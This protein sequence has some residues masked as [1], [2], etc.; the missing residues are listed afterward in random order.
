MIFTVSFSENSYTSTWSLG[1]THET[2][3]G[4]GGTSRLLIAWGGVGAAAKK[5]SDVEGD[6]SVNE[7]T[8]QRGLNSL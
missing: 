2:T 7:H 5:I 1:K 3:H 6:G 8:E 4:P